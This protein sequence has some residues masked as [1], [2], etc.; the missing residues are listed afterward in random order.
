MSCG[1]VDL[2]FSQEP[3]KGQ[4]P[5][6]FADCNIAWADIWAVFQHGGKLNQPKKLSI[7]PNPRLDVKDPPFPGEA[8]NQGD[9]EP[10]REKDG[11]G[12]GGDQYV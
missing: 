1:L 9:N 5:G 11:Q 7:F 4:H 6:V 12:D 2:G 10:E 3:S 8:Q